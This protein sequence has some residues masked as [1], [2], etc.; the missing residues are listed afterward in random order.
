MLARCD[1]TFARVAT[2]CS[3]RWA[4]RFS[5]QVAITIAGFF[6]VPPFM[7]ALLTFVPSE[8][9]S[10]LTIRLPRI[11]WRVIFSTRCPWTK[12]TSTRSRTATRNGS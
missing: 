5:D 8:S 10:R 4:R 9:C 7:G 1:E 3:G 12:P 11:A 2:A 6:T